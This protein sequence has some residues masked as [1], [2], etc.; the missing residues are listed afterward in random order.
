MFY[1]NTLPS[2][3]RYYGK[4]GRNTVDVTTIIARMKEKGVT[5]RSMDILSVLD[6]YKEEVRAAI[7]NGESVNMLDMVTAYIASVGS[8]D[9]ITGEDSEITLTVKA[10]ASKE[11]KSLVKDVKVV[12]KEVK[13][14]SPVIENIYDQYSEK[15]LNDEDFSLTANM[16]VT[17]TGSS[18]KLA[19][20][21]SGVFLAPVDEN[22]ALVSA[23]GQ[24]LKSPII[25]TNL[26]RTVSFYLPKSAKADTKYRIVLR[27]SYVNGTAL[28]KNIQT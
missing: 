17:L 6:A 21:D 10:T 3:K 2:G 28:R 8:V 4:F 11:L 14:T 19:G 1:E 26:P 15:N 13:D 20:D 16:A 24:W 23:E 27:T 9:S 7:K 5:M 25:Q 12:R 18:L 22:D